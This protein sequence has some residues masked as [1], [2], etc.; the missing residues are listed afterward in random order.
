M[1]ATGGSALVLTVAA[2]F[3]W[4]TPPQLRTIGCVVRSVSP[5]GATRDLCPC[6]TVLL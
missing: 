5:V 6:I 3:M 1:N 4:P 2:V